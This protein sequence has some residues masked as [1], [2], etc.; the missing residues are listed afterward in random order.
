MPAQHGPDHRPVSPERSGPDR[1]WPARVVT[2]RDALVGF[3]G[4]AASL[5]LAACTGSG[6]T[7]SSSG[8]APGPAPTTGGAAP[9]GT[10]KRGGKLTVAVEGN[11]LKDIMDAQN[12]L[13]KIDQA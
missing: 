8:T 13:A 3:G 7:N 1:F 9:S 2:R 6:P 12:D 10:P 5:A 11:G 4:V